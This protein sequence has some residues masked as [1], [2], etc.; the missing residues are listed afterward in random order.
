[1][2]LRLEIFGLRLGNEPFILQAF[3]QEE[4]SINNLRNKFGIRNLEFE[5]QVLYL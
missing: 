5:I 3:P 2:N 4:N 1:M